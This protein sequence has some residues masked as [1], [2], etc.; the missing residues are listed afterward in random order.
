MRETNSQPSDAPLDLRPTDDRE[1]ELL[2]HCARAVVEPQR[3][4]RIRELAT[5]GLNWTRLWQ[6]A[7]RNGLAPLLYFHLNQTGAAQIPNEQLE[8][9]RDYFQKNSAFSL[10]LTGELR[11]LLKSFNENGLE[12]VP[13][14]G[15][16]IA[17]KLYGNLALRQFCD[18]DILVRESDVWKA[19]ELIA[20]QGFVPHFQIPETKRAAFVR[21]SYVQ[22]FRRDEGRTL[23]E[24][25]WG[26]APRFFGVRFA[27]GSFWQGLETMSLQGTTIL[28][29]GAEDLLLMLCVHGAKD[30]WEKLEWVGSI[31]ELLRREPEF[32]WVRLFAKARQM[33][34]QRMLS[35]GLLLAHGLFTVPL[36]AQAAAQSRELRKLAQQVTQNFSSPEPPSQAF[37]S[38][39]RFHLRLKDNFAEQ[40]RHCLRLALT[41]TPVDWSTMSLPEPLSFAYPLL[42]AVRL[43][44]K[45]GL[46][47]EP[48]AVRVTPHSNKAA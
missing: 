48:A 36:P 46:N 6:L 1:L 18:L 11:R 27:A 45:Y 42:R 47:H 22:L 24:L 7:Q 17:Q 35:F 38:R 10:M 26:I 33:R 32:D 12:A 14:K 4:E 2:L 3:A 5:D 13:Y 25:H 16:A 37:T 15:P 40:V 21:L 29:P 23:V 20:A 9:L 30:C 31:A 41:T 39:L 43:T 8:F 44:R 28:T 19:S 34:C